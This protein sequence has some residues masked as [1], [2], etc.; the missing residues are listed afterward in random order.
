MRRVVCCICFIA[1]AVGLQA[2]NVKWDC[3]SSSG[4][5]GRYSFYCDIGWQSSLGFDVLVNPDNGGFVLNH[6]AVIVSFSGNVLEAT[7]GGLINETT[8]RHL[9]YSQYFVHSWIDDGSG[10]GTAEIHVQGGDD[11]YLAFVL[12]DGYDRSYVYGWVNIGVEVNGN[13]TLLG[14]AADLAGGPMIVG[15][16]GAIPEPSSGLLLLLGWAALGLR[17]K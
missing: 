15:G 11:F 5:Q 10:G 9:D 7:Q 16:G 6:G 13:L 8:T 2:A 3:V 4:V 17:R 1:L 12:G 14:S